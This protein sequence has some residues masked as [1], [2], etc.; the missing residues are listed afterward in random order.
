MIASIV[1]QRGTQYPDGEEYFS[2]SSAYPEYLFDHIARAPNA[3]YEMAR[4]ALRQAGLDAEHF[5]S[6]KWNPLGK[7][8]RP[9]ARVFVLC[10]FVHHRNPL[11][12]HR[13]FLSKC[14]HAS[15][16]RAVIDYVL[17]AAGRE[18]QVRFGNAPLQSCDWE[19]VLEQSGAAKLEE[20]YAAQSRDVQPRDLRSLVTKRGISG[21]ELT[22]VNRQP[23]QVCVTLSRT[24]ALSELTNGTAGEPPRFRVADY[25][26]RRTEASHRDGQ[27][28]YFLAKEILEADVVVSVP[29]LKTHEKVGITCG[30]KG[31]VGTVTDKDCLAHHRMGGS[32]NGGDEYPGSSRLRLLLAR[33]HDWMQTLPGGS[34]NRNFQLV[35]DRNVRRIVKRLGRVQTGAWYGNDT[36]WR[37]ALDLA[38]IVFFADSN[39]TIQFSRARRHLSFIDG[40]IAG[41]GEGPLKP[42]PVDG[43]VLVFSDDIV[44][45]DQIAA[46]L[47]GFDPNKIALVREAAALCDTIGHESRDARIVKDGAP[48]CMGSIAPV[49]GRAFKAPSG[50]R[51]RIEQAI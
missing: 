13:A 17:I 47:M 6:A 11:E 43:G 42:E 27:H 18:G 34:A 36:C 2:P 46:R 35:V 21:R 22:A 7:Y 31:F 4:E 24:S 10:N 12:G 16:V 28:R 49:L 29:K 5:G 19:A 51:G 3:A 33:Y 39:G 25:D 40:I 26:A 44:L 30:L 1:E 15:V 14:T 37:M 8:I 45:G 41:E 50:W 38:K 32:D 9:G 48:V 23:E 20:F